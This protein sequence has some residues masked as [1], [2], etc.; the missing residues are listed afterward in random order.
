MHMVSSSHV[1]ITSTMAGVMVML[2]LVIFGSII[3]HTRF[4]YA[5]QQQQ[6]DSSN[7]ST[8]TED[9]SATVGYIENTKKLLTQAQ[10]Q[11][12]AG[13][14]TEANNLVTTAY[15]DNFEYV[16]P[17]LIKHGSEPLKVDIE[18]MI[19]EQLRSMIEKQVPKEQVDD[20]ITAINAKLDQAITVVPEFPLGATMGIIGSVMVAVIIIGGRSGLWFSHRLWR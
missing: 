10:V 5:Q 19:R 16:E 9:L 6:P 12:D 13:N 14:F 15:L 20:Q 7:N 18:Q 11:Y 17:V 1:R 3:F 4:V 8:S 2:T